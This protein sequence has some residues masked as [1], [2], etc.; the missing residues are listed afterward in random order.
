[1]QWL[2]TYGP[3]RVNGK[4]RIVAIVGI[5]DDFSVEAYFEERLWIPLCAPE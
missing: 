4:S 1:L 3:L 5:K 2:V